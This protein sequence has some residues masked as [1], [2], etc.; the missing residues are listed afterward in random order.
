MEKVN[1][2]RALASLD[3]YWSQKIVGEANGSLIKVAKG[4]GDTHWHKHD[5]QDE[6]FIVY[7]GRLTIQLRSGDVTL[8]AGEMLVVPRGTEHCPKAE[9]AAAFVI[10]GTSVTST[11]EGGKPAW[12]ASGS[13]R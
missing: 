7:Q 9:E 13:A 12:S 1:I 2:E 6:V 3:E 4:I 10:L 8:E 11:A 5:D